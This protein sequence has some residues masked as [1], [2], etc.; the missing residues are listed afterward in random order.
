MPSTTL[1]FK[2]LALYHYSISP[3]WNQEQ[4]DKTKSAQGFLSSLSVTVSQIARSEVCTLAL[5]WSILSAFL[6][7][8]FEIY[9][10]IFNMPKLL[11]LIWLVSFRHYLWLETLWKISLQLSFITVPYQPLYLGNGPGIILS[12]WDWGKCTGRGIRIYRPCL[13]FSQSTS[14][15]WPL[16]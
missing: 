11:F 6:A 2:T 13:A 12:S 7:V 1:I 5:Q 16:L 8:Y 14:L 10:Y 3:T 9:L 4:R 15:L